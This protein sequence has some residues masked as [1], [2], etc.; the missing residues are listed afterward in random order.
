MPRKR[1]HVRKPSLKRNLQIALG[2]VL[3]ALACAPARAEIDLA[4]NWATRQHQDWQDRNPGPE[5]VN[6]LGLPIN[7][8]ARARALSYTASQLSLPERQCLFYPPQYIVLGPQSFKMWSETDPVSGKTI[9]WK[10]SAAGDRTILTIWMDGRPHPPENA[11]HPY[12]GFTTGAWE[13]S[14][15][16]TYTTHVK[17]GYI[18][19]N[20]VPSSDRATVTQ[21]FMR[22]GDTLT[23]TALVTDPVNLA[24]PFILS[25]SWKLDANLIIPTVPEACSPAAEVAR[26]DGTGTV[27][28]ILPGANT[29]TGEMTELFGIPKEA[30]LG[31]AETLYPEYRKKLQS[32]YVRPQKCTRYC[33]GWEGTAA[34]DTLKDCV[35]DYRQI[36][37]FTLRPPDKAQ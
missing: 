28:H 26:L 4:G 37:G 7:E 24:E 16:T 1:T 21:H 31:G 30:V 25:R 12:G 35:G 34:T 17:A 5:A 19:R 9:A 3:A 13:G 27:P 2:A 10:I 18:R 33:C 15:L 11:P 8:E 32:L 14:T 20:G 22:H 29:F 36:P 23:I 6:Y